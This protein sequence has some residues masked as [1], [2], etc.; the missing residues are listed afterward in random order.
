MWTKQTANAYIERVSAII[1]TVKKKH[2]LVK[3]VLFLISL[4]LETKT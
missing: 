1:E 4:V 3:I 2:P